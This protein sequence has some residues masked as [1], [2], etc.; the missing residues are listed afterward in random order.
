[1]AINPV[2]GSYQ[3]ADQSGAGAPGYGGINDRGNENVLLYGIVPNDPG[4][5]GSGSGR[6]GPGD[7]NIGVYS[8]QAGDPG[9]GGP[10][11]GPSNNPGEIAP[12]YAVQT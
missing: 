11:S 2:G 3:N 12:V 4:I 1:M 8:V 5:G 6:I 10:G 7:E 9:I